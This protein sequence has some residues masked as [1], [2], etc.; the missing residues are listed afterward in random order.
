MASSPGNKR[1]ML[2]RPCFRILDQDQ[3]ELTALPRIVQALGVVH[4]RR[5]C[6]CV[7]KGE[8]HEDVFSSLVYY[9]FCHS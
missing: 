9:R 2:E 8:L 4:R 5:L 1:E 7:C 3:E 6:Y